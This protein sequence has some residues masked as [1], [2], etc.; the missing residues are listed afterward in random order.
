MN[1][2]TFLITILTLLAT[3]QAQANNIQ[4]N[5]FNINPPTFPS[6]PN[7]SPPTLANLIPDPPTFP[8]FPNI[9]P[10]TLPNL[11]PGSNACTGNCGWNTIDVNG[12]ATLNVNPDI[13]SLNVQVSANG[14]TTADAINLLAQKINKVLSTLTSIGLNSNNW[15]TNSLSVYPNSS[16][17]NGN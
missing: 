4:G 12:A 17:I 14:K 15:Q 7:I 2:Y 16:Y 11:I 1:R 13:A 9:S 5:A 6:F 10:P 8:S 3:G